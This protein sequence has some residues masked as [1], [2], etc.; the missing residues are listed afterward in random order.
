[1]D[2]IDLDDDGQLDDLVL[3]DVSMVRVE[4]MDD[5]ALWMKFYGADGREHAVRVGIVEKKLRILYEEE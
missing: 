4:R 5:A 2:R 3:N 1:M